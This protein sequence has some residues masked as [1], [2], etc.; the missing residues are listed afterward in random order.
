[1]VSK[2]NYL[3]KNL[4]SLNFLILEIF[5]CKGEVVK[6]KS[7]ELTVN[8]SK[9]QFLSK[10]LKP[11]PN[12]WHGFKDVEERFRKRYLDLL[13]NPEVKKR[14]LIRTLLVREIRRYLDNLGFLEVET[15]TL[16]S[17]YGGANAKPF[18]THINMLDTD[19]YLRIADELYLK[20]LVVGG[21]EKV[22]EICKDFRNE[23]LDLTHQ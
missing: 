12:E 21:Y 6:T 3:E 15:P 1:M 11:L 16:Q 2:K 9:F 23:G 7:G 13:L 10:A 14:F 22:Y 19:M 18:I 20:R 17:L 5:G 8:V 4:R